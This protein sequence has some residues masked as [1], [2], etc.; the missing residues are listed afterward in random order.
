V[1]HLR[2]NNRGKHMSLSWTLPASPHLAHV[3]VKRTRGG[4]CSTG[5]HDGVTI[6][7]TGVHTRAVDTTAVPGNR[8]CYTVFVTNKAGR[9]S[10]ADDTG[11]VAMP[12][13][14]PPPAVKH[15]AMSLSGS[16]V[17]LSWSPAPSATHYLVMRGPAGACPTRSDA[18]AALAKPF[19]ATFT[20]TTAKAGT[21]YCY[22]V[23]PVDKYGNVQ[24]TATAFATA[25][26]PAPA[27]KPAATPAPAASYSSSAPFASIV[28]LM[29]AA[30]AIAVVA[31][32]LILLAA[33]RLQAR[34]RGDVYQP[35]RVRG[36]ALRV[37]LG[38]AD[39]RA[40]IIPAALGVGAMLLALAVAILVL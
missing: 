31:F 34:M 29:V 36:G 16:A 15:V 1:T 19:A 14:T 2:F 8:Y 23:F 40:L 20:D 32:S 6:G 22:A 26:V 5:L 10:S 28:A 18:A 35:S 21:A 3:F 9:R 25:T 12:D 37:Q 7:S 33:L 24:H 4:S 11:L 27:P 30:V 39:A 13:H 17:V 38:H